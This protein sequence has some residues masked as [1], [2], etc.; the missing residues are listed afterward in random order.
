MDGQCWK[1][2][3]AGWFLV[4][5]LQASGAALELGGYIGLENRVFWHPSPID[6]VPDFF[7]GSI[8]GQ[9]EVA[10]DMEGGG[11][12]VFTPFLRWDPKD[13]ERTH[14]DI[15]VLKWEQS[16]GC[17]SLRAGMDKVFWGVTE[18]YHLVDVINQTD[19]LE[20]QDYEEK[21]G[22]PM[23]N[24]SYAF[25][26]QTIEIFW[27]PFFRERRFP[28][29][30]GRFRT[31]LP[32][33]T[34]L[35]TF[36][37]SREEKHS[38][39]A[40]RWFATAGDL[41]IGVSWFSGTQREPE[42]RPVPGKGVLAPHYPLMQQIGLDA[43]WVQDSYLLK[44]EYLHRFDNGDPWHAAVTGV[45]HTLYGLWE[46]TAD[47]GMMV[48]YLFDSRGKSATST[49]DNDLFFGVRLVLNNTGDF[50][51][52]TGPLVDLDTR[53]SLFR[54]EMEGRLSEQWKLCVN[55]YVYANH[56]KG[57][58]FYSLRHDD[59]SEVLLKRYF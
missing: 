44:V 50:T 29:S 54:F 25:G 16:F 30:E 35:A 3:L 22:Q 2:L 12:L 11:S 58:S 36:S 52:V 48:E 27:L 39:L 42:L 46:T 53:A 32:V 45:E 6:G 24:I 7:T 20:Q 15:R 13:T 19:I 51:C 14:G 18:S 41:D 4:I 59:F 47:L 9:M 1:L 21:L 55:T 33:D 43:Q 56:D 37:A 40:L 5:G 10:Q 28:G 17:V 23:V 34:D 57:E 8:F 49:F 38:D 31:P 26:D